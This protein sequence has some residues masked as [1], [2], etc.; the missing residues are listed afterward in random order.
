MTQIVFDLDYLDRFLDRLGG[1]SP[2]PLLLGV[3]PLRSYRLALRFHNELPGIVVP[4]ALQDAPA[5]RR[6]ATRPT[7]GSSTRSE[8]LAETRDRVEGVYLVAPYRKPLRV[9]ELLEG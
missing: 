5:R 7:S 9:L 2:I 3:C 1:S 4:E 8:L 6:R